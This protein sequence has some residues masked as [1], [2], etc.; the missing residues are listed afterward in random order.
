[1]KTVK[2]FLHHC[3]HP[4]CHKNFYSHCKCTQFWKALRGLRVHEIVM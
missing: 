1:M 2:T 4:N 3:S